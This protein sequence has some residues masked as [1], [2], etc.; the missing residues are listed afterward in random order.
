MLQKNLLFEIIQD[1][2]TFFEPPCIY[3]YIQTY[4]G[5]GEFLLR[6]K[7]IASK[8]A[9]T[10]LYY[11]YYQC[12]LAQASTNKS[13]KVSK[14]ATSL[15][16]TSKLCVSLWQACCEHA[17]WFGFTILMDIILNRWR[18]QCKY[19]EDLHNKIDLKT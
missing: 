17:F 10:S 15:F 14:L 11:L 16:C 1:C 18:S 4:F 19:L 9:C 8:Q 2:P 6:L 3:I 12:K 13:K 5:L 7:L